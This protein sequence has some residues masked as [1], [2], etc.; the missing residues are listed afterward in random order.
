[1]TIANVAN[2][3]ENTQA[4]SLAENLVG[5]EGKGWTY[6][7]F[8]LG[9]ERSNSMT[10]G[11]KLQQR[12]LPSYRYDDQRPARRSTRNASASSRMRR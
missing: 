8:L 2:P 7:K 3:A 4:V 6:A 1:M 9:F 10:A 12:R 11:L 5:E